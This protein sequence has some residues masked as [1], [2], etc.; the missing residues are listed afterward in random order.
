MTD[1]K[2]EKKNTK[3]PTTTPRERTL[4][5]RAQAAVPRA[6]SATYQ[7]VLLVATSP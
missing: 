2:A 6:V 7:V 5:P 1:K 3:R 4:P